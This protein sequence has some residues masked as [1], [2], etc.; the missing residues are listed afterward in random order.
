MATHRLE[1]R[2][3]D[4]REANLW[5][6]GINSTVS[7]FG[8]EGAR[9][10]RQERQILDGLAPGHQT[11][12]VRELLI[13]K[14]I[15]FFSIFAPDHVIGGHD[16][17]RNMINTLEQQCAHANGSYGM[18]EVNVLLKQQYGYNLEDL[19]QLELEAPTSP[20]MQWQSLLKEMGYTHEQISS[21]RQALGRSWGVPAS[22]VD[23]YEAITEWLVN[24]TA[25]PKATLGFVSRDPLYA[26]GP[27]LERSDSACGAPA[28]AKKVGDR[29][30][31]G[32]VFLN[33]YEK[34]VAYLE[35]QE[36]MPKDAAQVSAHSLAPAP[37]VGADCDHMWMQEYLQKSMVGDVPQ[38]DTASPTSAHVQAK[39]VDA[40]VGG[41]QADEEAVQGLPA[42]GSLAYTQ[43]GV[44]SPRYRSPHKADGGGVTGQSADESPPSS[45]ASP[46]RASYS[47]QAKVD[48]VSVR[49]RL[50]VRVV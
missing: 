46:P 43:T 28:T 42:V 31:E 44:I 48:D 25:E 50:E 10:S 4:A 35:A 36:A 30:G 37:C 39:Q 29:S 45:P 18:L 38:G 2:A 23:D 20:A 1:L 16:R 19:E 24:N 21:A 27:E 15:R 3:S 26:K 13:N 40:R 47:K 12:L 17:Y 32:K 6:K 7:K 34:A 22:Q 8:F 41:K 33:E 11:H 49:P 5:I 9:P 14:V